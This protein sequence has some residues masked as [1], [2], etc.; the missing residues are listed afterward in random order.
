VINIDIS[1][2]MLGFLIEALEFRIAAFQKEKVSNDLSANAASD[3]SNDITLLNVLLSDFRTTNATFN[4]AGVPRGDPR[5]RAEL[6]L[7]MQCLLTKGFSEAEQ[8]AFVVMGRTASPDPAWTG[9]LY[10][11]DRFGLDGSIEAA[12]D[13]V[14][15]YQPMILGGPKQ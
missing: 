7:I 1:A 2:K 3:L 9:Y 4:N 15:S 8:D 12:L 11:P 6:R 14:F 10:W 13:K 5:Q